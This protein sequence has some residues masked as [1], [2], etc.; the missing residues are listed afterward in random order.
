M[1]EEVLKSN[2]SEGGRDN[3]GLAE[4]ENSVAFRKWTVPWPYVDLSF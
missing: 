3:C 1:I 2:G 4:Q